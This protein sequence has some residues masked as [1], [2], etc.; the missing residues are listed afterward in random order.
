MQ[1]TPAFRACRL[2]YW[3]YNLLMSFTATVENDSIKLPPGIHLP[4]GTEVVIEPREKAP[5][6][7]APE[8]KTLAERYAKFI[9]VV[10][11]APPDLAENLDH[12]LYGLPKRTP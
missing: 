11:D 9:G 4:D 12:Y 2:P 6:A 10:K 3:R 1:I 5:A 7:A 8:R